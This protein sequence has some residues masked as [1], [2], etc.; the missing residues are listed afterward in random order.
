MTNHVAVHVL[1]QGV[2]GCLAPAP[3]PGS[4]IAG[5]FANSAFNGLR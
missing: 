1:V 4:G 2:R 5:L 3:V